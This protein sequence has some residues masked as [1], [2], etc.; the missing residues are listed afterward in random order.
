MVGGAQGC[1]QENPAYS[2]EVGGGGAGGSGTCKALPGNNGA[3]EF[4][5]PDKNADANSTE[6]IRFYDTAC[7]QIASDT[8]RIVTS[9]PNNGAETVQRTITKFQP[10][11]TTPTSV[12][13]ETASYTGGQFDAN[14]Y[15][16]IVPG[17]SRMAQS[18]LNVGGTLT[19]NT[20]DEYIAGAVNGSQSTF[21]G[22]NAGYNV[23]GS[24]SLNQ[25]FGWSSATDSS[26][27]CSTLWA[28]SSRSR[29]TRL[30]GRLTS[31]IS[32]RA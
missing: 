19:A 11:V 22:D 12:R 26:N 31:W 30:P 10:N 24:A 18:Q 32:K 16:I 14:Y 5:V 28:P 9:L 23:I 17:L 29:V 27:G 2:N 6:R 25:T 1:P 15:P 20:A 21:C 13:T 4:F 3:T 7:G 8:V